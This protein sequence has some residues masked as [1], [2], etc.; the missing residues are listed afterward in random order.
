LT[1]NRPPPI[2]PPDVG[3]FSRLA[4]AQIAPH[5]PLVGQRHRPEYN[6]KNK[7]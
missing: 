6:R 4:E 3:T 1:K 2:S 7:G 5:F